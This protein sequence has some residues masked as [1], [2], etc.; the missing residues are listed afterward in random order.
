MH[1]FGAV[2]IE[3]IP[4]RSALSAQVCIAIQPPR[5]YVY[6]HAPLEAAVV[7]HAYAYSNISKQMLSLV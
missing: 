7:V 4:R 3:M 2:G 1:T 6:V 5:M